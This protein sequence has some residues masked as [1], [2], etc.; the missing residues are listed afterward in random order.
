MR[1]HNE[2]FTT[3]SPEVSVFTL[4]EDRRMIFIATNQ[5]EA[6]LIV[7]EISTNI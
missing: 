6:S 7:W 2:K 1:P 4:S 3:V 5:I